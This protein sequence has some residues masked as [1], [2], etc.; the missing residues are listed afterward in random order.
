MPNNIMVL[1][2]VGNH[3]SLKMYF[4]VTIEYCTQPT[5]FFLLYS[6]ANFNTLEGTNS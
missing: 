4:D 5:T 1:D 2:L 3:R 6:Q